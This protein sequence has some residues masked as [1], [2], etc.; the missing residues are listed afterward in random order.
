MIAVMLS[1]MAERPSSTRALCALGSWLV[2]GIGVWG[3][4]AGVAKASPRWSAPRPCVTSGEFQAELNA[5]GWDRDSTLSFVVK[6]RDG[7]YRLQVRDG[8]VITHTLRAKGCKELLDAALMILKLGIEGPREEPGDA[9]AATKSPTSSAKKGQANARRSGQ[10]STA[11]QSKPSVTGPS[12]APSR[13]AEEDAARKGRPSTS[14]PTSSSASTA[15]ST[16]DGED[17]QADSQNKAGRK[18]GGGPRPKSDESPPVVSAKPAVVKRRA[19]R[20]RIR[21]FGRVEAGGGGGALPGFQGQ[22]LASLGG[23]RGR[24]QLSGAGIFRFGAR[25]PDRIEAVWRARFSVW[26][27]RLEGCYVLSSGAF[28]WPLCA[29]GEFGRMKS[30]RRAMNSG[31]GSGVGSGSGSGSIPSEVQSWWWALQLQ[32]RGEWDLS[33]W[34]FVLAAAE[35]SFLPRR[36]TIAVENGP[37]LCCGPVSAAMRLGVGMRWGRRRF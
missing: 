7:G 14:G 16:S 21:G 22:V 37:R 35:V 8:G 29:G 5:R 24:W 32:A 25:S 18:A 28:R 2:V 4:A 33:R 11:P 3:S 15:P 20:A 13:R 27:G 19:K 6:A 26:A 34:F 1:F 9:S 23:E 30:W 17:S 31:A 36:P 12:S 10:G